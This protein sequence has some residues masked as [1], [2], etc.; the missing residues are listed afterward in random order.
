MG[1]DIVMLDTSPERANE[2]KEEFM[3]KDTNNFYLF[4]KNGTVVGFSR[5]YNVFISNL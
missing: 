3:P 1:N 4:R 5:L 2:S